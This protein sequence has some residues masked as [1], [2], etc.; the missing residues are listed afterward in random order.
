MG[1]AVVYTASTFSLALLELMVNASAPRIPPGM[2]YV[3]VDIPDTLRLDVLDVATLPENW[4]LS[5]AP[6]QC[7]LAGDAWAHRGETVGLIVPSAVARIE[8]NVLL[9]PKHADFGRLRIGKLDA[10]AI[11]ERLVR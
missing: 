5:P 6:P 2:V 10:I 11:D 1:V 7:R 3:P 4:F 9:N 8:N